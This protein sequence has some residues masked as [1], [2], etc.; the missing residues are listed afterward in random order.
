MKTYEN[1]F[2]IE[3]NSSYG[4]ATCRGIHGDAYNL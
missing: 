4:L 2:F 1:K 3:L